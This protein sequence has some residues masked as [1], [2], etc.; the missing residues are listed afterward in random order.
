MG[1]FGAIA[2]SFA[3]LYLT[4]S[5]IESI[6]DTVTPHVRQVL[7]PAAVD[8]S[9]AIYSH[10]SVKIDANQPICQCFFAEVA[11]ICQYLVAN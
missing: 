4:N 2:I 10:L 6:D 9:S 11:D 3:F 8:R 5:R 7:S 1:D